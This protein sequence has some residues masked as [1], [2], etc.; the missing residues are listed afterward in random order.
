MKTYLYSARLNYT[1][2]RHVMQTCAN[3][4]KTHADHAEDDCLF[5]ASQFQKSQLTEFLEQV[6]H[7]GGA[8]LTITCGPYV[9]KQKIV[10]PV[11]DKFTDKVS[12]VFNTSGDATLEIGHAPKRT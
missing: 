6:F 3:C 10:I 5:E 11:V 9:L 7:E 4:Q 8:E 2:K 12:T 1:F